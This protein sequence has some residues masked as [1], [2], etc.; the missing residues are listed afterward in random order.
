MTW[1]GVYNSQYM[2]SMFIRQDNSLENAK[3]LGYLDAHELYPDFKPR[4]IEEYI[5]ESIE[6]TIPKLYG[7]KAFGDI[8]GGI[9]A[10]RAE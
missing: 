4:T 1:A 10:R 7:G 6:G 8:L 3:Y 2:Y 9:N 5:K